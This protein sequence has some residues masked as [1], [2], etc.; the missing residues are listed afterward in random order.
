MPASCEKEIFIDLNSSDPQIVIEGNIDNLSGPYYV[1][2]S[3]MVN[4]SDDNTFPPVTGAQVI[5]SDN[6]GVKDT[7]T[8]KNAGVYRTRRIAG[9]PGITY[10]MS[11]KTGSKSFYATSTMP[12]TVNLDSLRFDKL[13]PEGINYYTT[14]IYT[15]PIEPGNYYRFLQTIN[16]YADYAT[17]TVFNDQMNNGLVNTRPIMTDKHAI[18]LGDTIKVEMRCIDSNIYIYYLGLCNVAGYNFLITPVNPPNN[19]TGDYALGYFSAHTVQR[20]TQIVR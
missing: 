9:R 15:D 2:L 4:F 17:I 6:T 7:L 13:I 8:E 18:E 5:I 3:W 19:I 12:K 20:R 16:K 10:S 11:I 14:P 1:K